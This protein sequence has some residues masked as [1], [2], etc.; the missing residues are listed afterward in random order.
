MLAVDLSM[1]LLAD[2]IDAVLP[3]TQC[4]RCGYPAC[5]PYADAVAEG[6]TDINRCPPGGDPVIV[7]LAALTGRRAKPLDP[8]CGEHKP[9]LVA[10]IDEATCIGC[11]L[12]IAACPVDA[13]LG[14]QKR[15]H[16]VLPSLCTGCEL[17]LAPCPVDCIALRPAGRA[18]SGTD[19]AAARE[20]FLGREA[21]LA[22][23]ERVAKR[24]ANEAPSHDVAA[25]ARRQAA[26]AAALARARARRRTETF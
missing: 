12:C 11:T 9:L 17:C 25:R 21:R 8:K 1:T 20:R 4:T 7:A 26:I 16:T 3:Q 14:A 19:A 6:T 2:R 18:W 24:T 10:V 5:R 22:R 23:N 13:I 15:M